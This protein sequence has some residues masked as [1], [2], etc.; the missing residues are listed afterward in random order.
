MTYKYIFSSESN[1]FYSVDLQMLYEQSESWPKNY[2][3]ITDAK[4][5]EMLEGQSKGMDI[6]ADAQG[7]PVL[8]ERKPP[9]D[10]MQIDIAERQKAKLMKEAIDTIDIL[11]DATVLGISTQEENDSLISWKKYRVLLN[12]ID[13]R[14]APDISWPIKPE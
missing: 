14:K 8:I 12:R 7:Y 5:Q 2:V 11:Q 13:T 10:Q 6:K 3:Y 4:W 1:A 9:S